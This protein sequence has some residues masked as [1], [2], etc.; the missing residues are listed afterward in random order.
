MPAGHVGSSHFHPPLVLA[1][2]TSPTGLIPVL[3]ITS[4]ITML[5]LT[6]QSTLTRCHTLSS[7]LLALPPPCPNTDLCCNFVLSSSVSLPHIQSCLVREVWRCHLRDYPD[8][9]FV[10]S[11]LHII[12]FSA[13]LSFTG[14]H[15]AQSC[16]NLKSANNP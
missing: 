13:N 1:H 14:P 10:N 15:L 16:H 2:W 4:P 9:H 6:S 5:P 7:F 12:D 8:Q 3:T 11:L